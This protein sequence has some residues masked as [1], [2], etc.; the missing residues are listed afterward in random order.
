M[1]GWKQEMIE[2]EAY[3]ECQEEYDAA[4]ES[5]HQQRE[6]EAQDALDHDEQAIEELCNGSNN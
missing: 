2:A 5:W 1:S 6:L 3:K 4:M